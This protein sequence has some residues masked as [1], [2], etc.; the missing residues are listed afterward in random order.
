MWSIIVA[1]FVGFFAGLIARAIHPGRDKAGFIVTTLL[2]ISGSVLVTYAG[3]ALGWYNANSTAGFFASIVGAVLIL[4][5]Y[6]LLFQRDSTK[7]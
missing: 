4:F 5:V 7:N 2:G 1:I 3:R 6:N